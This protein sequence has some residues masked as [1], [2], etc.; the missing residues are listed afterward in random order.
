[1]P[2]IAVVL[3][4][5]MRWSSHKGYVLGMPKKLAVFGGSGCLQGYTLWMTVWL[6]LEKAMLPKI[7]SY[8]A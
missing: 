3:E 4:L 1:M 2:W 7:S 5:D 8:K 6:A